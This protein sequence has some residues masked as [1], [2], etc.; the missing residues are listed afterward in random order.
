MTDTQH[1]LIVAADPDNPGDEDL[2]EYEVECP[3]VTDACR[4]YEDCVPDDHE[5]TLL[6]EAVDNETEPIAHGVKHLLLDG[7][8]CAA[9]DRCNVRDHDALPNE[10]AGRFPVGRHAIDFDFGDATEIEV[11]LSDSDAGAVA[12]R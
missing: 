8:W 3:G 11:F 2:Y 12:T 1:F 9:T 10:V 5:R 4:R 6:E 7:M